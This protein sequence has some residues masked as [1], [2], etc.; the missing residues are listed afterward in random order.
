[1]HVSVEYACDDICIFSL[2]LSMYVI[3]KEDII[4]SLIPISS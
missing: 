2:Y 3:S 4:L 1:M